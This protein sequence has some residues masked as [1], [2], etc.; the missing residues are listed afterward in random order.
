MPISPAESPRPEPLLV[1]EDLEAG[2]GSG[3]VVRGVSAQVAA[4]EIATVVGP[5]G[6]GK[7]T[8][9]KAITGGIPSAGG[10]VLIGADDVTN[11]RR[12]VLVRSGVGYV[13][14]EREVFRALSV[15]DN[16]AA[17]GYL[18]RRSE[19]HRAMD[20]VLTMFPRLARLL[21]SHAGN[22][23]GGERK[24]LAMARVLML[25]PRVMILDE[26]SANLSP[27]ASEALLGETVPAL[28]SSGA[29][30]LLVEQ[31][32]VQALEVSNW[33]YVMVSGRFDV[34]GPAKVVAARS[35]IGELFLG[36]TAGHE[37]L[38]KAAE[39]SLKTIGA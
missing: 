35:D 38:V 10:R 29:A 21:P 34:D 23:S 3:L 5:N 32:A 37:G 12:D 19:L 9:L 30:V 16:L 15:R 17:G 14:Q 13:P 2:Y 33:A 1:V 4:G 24:M 27:T 36:S 8:L 20:R 31:R 25:E 6:S 18:L 26:P 28:A 22:L 39:R 11:L 7:S